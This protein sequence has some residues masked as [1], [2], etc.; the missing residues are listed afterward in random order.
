MWSLTVTAI[1]HVA[2]TNRLA[3]TVPPRFLPQI[4][5]AYLDVLDN[6]LQLLHVLQNATA[7]NT[8]STEQNKTKQHTMAEHLKGS[9]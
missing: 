3:I 1:E 5:R 6:F 7:S 2:A 4:A 9:L 8:P